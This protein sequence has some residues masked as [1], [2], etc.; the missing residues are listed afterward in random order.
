MNSKYHYIRV[1]KEQDIFVKISRSHKSSWRNRLARSTVNRE[2]VGSIP[3]EDALFRFASNSSFCKDFN[4]VKPKLNRIND[5][6]FILKDKVIII[7]SLSRESLFFPIHFGIPNLNEFYLHITVTFEAID[8]WK[9][10]L[11]SFFVYD[12]TS[13]PPEYSLSC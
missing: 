9:V 13:N 5:S 1:C 12:L 11:S 4:C 3:T 6:Y 10:A 7:M 2:V 8:C